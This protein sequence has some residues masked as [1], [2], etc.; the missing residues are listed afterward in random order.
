MRHKNDWNSE[1]S[2][3]IRVSVTSKIWAFATGMLGICIP[4]SAATNSGPILPIA[5]ITGATVGTVSI[6]NSARKSP[7]TIDTDAKFQQLES[8]IADLETIIASEGVDL[9]RRIPTKNNTEVNSQI[10]PES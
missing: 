3:D 9:T 4:L 5:V 2:K 10:L 6:W 1:K 8:R 7:N